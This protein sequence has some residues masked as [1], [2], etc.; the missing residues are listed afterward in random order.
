MAYLRI[1]D[2]GGLQHYQ[3]GKNAKG[4]PKW[5]K[6]YRCLLDDPDFSRLPDSAKFHVLGLFLVASQNDNRIPNDPAWIAARIGATDSVNLS[7]L[8]PWVQILGKVPRHSREEER[9]EEKSTTPAPPKK[10]GGFSAK[11]W[12]HDE[13]KKHYNRSPKWAKAEWVALARVAKDLPESEF[14]AAWS[15]FLGTNG[16]FFAGHY[17]RVWGQNLEKF[18]DGVP[19]QGHRPANLLTPGRELN[20][21][22]ATHISDNRD[23][24]VR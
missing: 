5:I 9:R 10:P 24:V 22:D 18:R 3:T 15:A 2:F 12:A 7:L 14:R 21:A 1:K 4:P 23:K 16:P 8:K 6:L 17:P 13:W 20:A 19:L 11:D